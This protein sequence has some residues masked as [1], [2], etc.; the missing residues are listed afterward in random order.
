MSTVWIIIDLESLKR[1]RINQYFTAPRK[2]TAIIR[3]VETHK[4]TAHSNTFCLRHETI[5]LNNLSS[6]RN[7]V[8]RFRFFFRIMYS[9][10]CYEQGWN[11]RGITTD[12]LIKCSSTYLLN[13]DW[14]HTPNGFLPEATCHEL[15]TMIHLPSKGN[16][17]FAT[18]I[19]MYR[20]LI[21]WCVLLESEV[22]LKSCLWDY[23]V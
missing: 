3:H 18:V 8:L 6:L 12:P 20:S 7:S 11:Y 5:S 16:N 10:A 17:D 14:F 9:L 4:H 21:S 23:I 15:A 1:P 2:R 22:C 19:S 13:S